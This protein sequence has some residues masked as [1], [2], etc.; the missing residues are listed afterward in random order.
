MFKYS[1]LPRFFSVLFVFVISAPA[2]AVPTDL[3]GSLW[4]VSAIDLAGNSWSGSTLVFTHQ[5]PG[6]SSTNDVVEGY[7]DWVG[8]NVSAGREEFRGTFNSDH[9]LNVTGF[10]LVNP[11]NIVLANYEA[12]VSLD[13]SSIYNGIWYGNN[14][15]N[16]ND[17]SALRAPPETPISQL[18]DV[19]PP[20]PTLSDLSA[21]ASCSYERPG[22]CATANHPKFFDLETVVDYGEDFSAT[23][24]V[25]E[26]EDSVI[27]AIKG[28]DSI[29]DWLGTNPTFVLPFGVPTIAFRR[30]LDAAVD[31]YVELK[32]RFPE[33]RITL[34]G[35]SL[36]GAL[37]QLVGNAARVA[38]RTFN[39]PGVIDTLSQ[40]VV[41]ER[42]ERVFS[43]TPPYEGEVTN[44]RVY[45][46]LVSTIGR[47][48]GDDFTWD[49]P[50]P[51]TKE[52][53][54]NFPYV[55][56]KDNHAMATVNALVTSNAPFSDE[57]GPRL[58]EV[59][60]EVIYADFPG[61]GLVTR[62]ATAAVDTVLTTAQILFID[63]DNIDRYE[64][65]VGVGGTP[66][67]SIVFPFANGFDALYELSVFDSNSWIGLGTFAE[68]DQYFFGPEGVT[69]LAFSVLD[70][71]TGMVPDEVGSLTFGLSITQD[72]VLRGDVTGISTTFSKQVPAPGTIYL[73]GFGVIFYFNRRRWLSKGKRPAITP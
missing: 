60:D 5:A 57:Y 55:A 18:V 29:R 36:G 42:L 51:L 31:S 40:D 43:T 4:D 14:V 63:P 20:V 50:P 72:G 15:I 22:T 2:I 32:K 21:A 30:Q 16:S 53:I 37:A 27:L 23:A 38:T 71:A 48:I 34:T 67:R 10:N 73:L 58:S 52:G 62:A 41:F 17:W 69:D 39:A 7:F 45:G 6:T 8:S 28:T 3:T 54:N 33:S 70:A 1:V 26:N 44:F 35:H 46:D 24:L 66:I 56:A 13:G 64:F 11:E 9:T 61:V 49:P 19:P 68:F 25:S 59:R 65:S 12:K 47:T